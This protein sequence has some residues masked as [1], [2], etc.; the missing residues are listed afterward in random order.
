MDDK[1]DS[2]VLVTHG[3]YQYLRHPSY[4]GWFYWSIGTQLLLCNPL[5]TLLY[6]YVSWYFFASRIPY[7]EALLVDFY[8]DQYLR[9][10]ASTALGIPFIAVH[11]AAPLPASTKDE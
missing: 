8:G 4:F 1:R 3:I 7:E 6:T 5:C 9:Y 10:I 2:H 11:L